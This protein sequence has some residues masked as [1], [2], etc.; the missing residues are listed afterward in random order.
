MKNSSPEYVDDHVVMA[1][2]HAARLG[3]DRDGAEDYVRNRLV[4]ISDSFPSAD[5]LERE[6]SRRKLDR[7]MKLLN[8]PKD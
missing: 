4:A 5:D 6:H 1:L 8:D 3:M 7:V 2:A